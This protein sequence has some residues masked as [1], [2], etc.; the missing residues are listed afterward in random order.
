VNK[1][2]LHSIL[3]VGLTIIFSCGNQKKLAQKQNQALLYQ[4]SANVVRPEYQ[5]YHISD[6][7]SQLWIK[8]N[9]NDLLFNQANPENKLMAKIKI[10]YQLMDRTNDP[11]N[12]QITDSS[13]WTKNFEKIQGKQFILLSLHIKAQFGYQYLLK[14]IIGDL[15]REIENTAYITINKKNIYSA[16]NFK[17]FY[18]ETNAPLFNN[19]LSASDSFNIEW[20][21]PAKKIFIKYQPDNLALPPPPFSSIAE[22]PFTFRAD[23]VW[24]L[25]YSTKASYN[26]P[27]PGLYLIQT[28]TLAPEGLYLA[29]FGAS[30]PK[31]NEIATMVAPVEY[32]STTSEYKAIVDSSNLKVAFDNFW[33]KLST[34]ANI[35]RELIRIY[36]N[37]MQYANKYF[38]SYK[39]GWKT[40]RGMIYM[41]FGTPSYIK[42]TERSETWEYYVMQNASNLTINFIKTASPY[43]DCYYVMQRNSI[44]T[45]YWRNAVSSWRNGF[46]YS[47]EE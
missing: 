30:F 9:S 12:A 15:L 34:N 19:Y 17:L 47:L 25:P 46:A 21:R 42:K 37:R 44:F 43:S 38:T 20:N 28:D 6:T 33:L 10:N 32:L 23:S 5:V 16:Q 36:Y 18:S 11:S 8:I 45:S 39:P 4:P 26:L 40:D 24:I 35:S 41:I 2:I 31:V 13:S 27:Y 22:A 7:V 1:V 3:L 29:N 14:I